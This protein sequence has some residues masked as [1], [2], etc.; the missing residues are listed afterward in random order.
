MP[1]DKYSREAEWSPNFSR[2]DKPRRQKAPT[3]TP[4][5]ARLPYY[6][7]GDTQTSVQ[8]PTA[9]GGGGGDS[10]RRWRDL[11]PSIP[12]GPLTTKKREMP[13]RFRRLP[14]RATGNPFM[15]LRETSIVITTNLAARM[16][17]FSRPRTLAPSR[18]NPIRQTGSTRPENKRFFRFTY[19]IILDVKKQ[20]EIVHLVRCTTEWVPYKMARLRTL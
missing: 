11:R 1:F 2:R 16:C 6:K 14:A 10:R 5:C 4:C 15:R 20:T 13:Q 9:G 12:P 19:C 8:W 3:Y 18:C 7:L 17:E